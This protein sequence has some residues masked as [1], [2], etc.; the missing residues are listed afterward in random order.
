MART[1]KAARKPRKSGSS[2]SL[3]KTQILKEV[4]ACLAAYT[5]R[6]KSFFTADTRLSAF[7]Q[8]NARRRIVASKLSAWPA[9][10]AQGL[11]LTV[12]TLTTAR[13]LGDL[14]AVF[15]AA[16]RK[17]DVT[18]A[19]ASGR[20]SRIPGKK[21]VK[22]AAAKRPRSPRKAVSGKKAARKATRKP[23][24][25]PIARK[26][27]A[28]KAARKTTRPKPAAP[29]SSARMAVPRPAAPK[30]APPILDFTPPGVG[31]RFD[32]RPTTFELNVGAEAEIPDGAAPESSPI[33]T[34]APVDGDHDGAPPT[35]APSSKAVPPPPRRPRYANAALLEQENEKLFNR[36]SVDFS[37]DQIIRLRL[38]IGELSAASQVENPTNFPADKL[39]ED[40]DLDVMVSSTDLGVAIDAESLK[41]ARPSVAHGYFFLPGD[42]GPAHTRDHKKYLFLF[43]KLPPDQMLWHGKVSHARIGYYYRNIL[44]QS[45]HLTIR[46]REKNFTIVTDF[47][48]SDDLTGL[49]VIPDRPRISIFTNANDDGNHHIVMRRPGQATSESSAAFKVN[50]TNVGGTIKKLRAALS[51]RAP[52]KKPRSASM[53]AEDLR[54]LAPIGRE[55]YNQ[56][57][58]QVPPSFFGGIRS[59]PEDFVI[60]IAR[61]ASSGF[62][63]PWSYIYEIPLF[64]G[65]TPQ[66]CPMVAKWD[67]SRPLFD[68]A[69][70]QCPHGPHPRDVL[71]PFGFWGYRYAIEQL[72]STDEPPINIPAIANCD[73]VIGETQY[74]IDPESL[75]GHVGRLRAI[76]AS[77]PLAAQLREGKNRASIGTLLGADLPFVYFYCHGER[78]NIADPNTYLGVGNHETITA[79]DFIGW[80]DVWYDSLHKKIWDAVRPLV[81]INACH[82]LAIEPE[83]LVSYLDAFVSRGRASGVIG[84]EVKVEQSM[85]MDVAESFIAAWM[86]G[87]S[88]VEEALWAI[89]I[90]YLKQGNMFGLVYTPYCWSELKIVKR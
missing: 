43:L 11:R 60:Q 36:R 28:K 1:K 27:P 87:N 78:L 86:S 8:G 62:V 44:I 54:Q 76:L 58:G 14:I 40:V 70:R 74:G 7:I 26:A 72:S 37:P 71:C 10:R 13:N 83:T 9:L 69:P 85:A 3:G 56:L 38:D 29:R 16:L 59:K 47:T 73:V 81:F 20:P 22:K 24:T 52:E 48:T 82:A 23:S 89:R 25:S 32:R 5:G 15:Q 88:S 67:D 64:S 80:T 31:L 65:V 45:Q 63:L 21:S 49:D 33:D 50:S 55:L 61:P 77:T 53:L 90:D 51:M 2:G 18:T 75:N 6:P 57:P 19:S 17:P 79:G 66:L 39:P 68:G 84:T 4:I 46:P 41:N 42:G 30:P 35:S 12:A 34:T